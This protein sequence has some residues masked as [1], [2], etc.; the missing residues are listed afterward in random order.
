MDQRE[1]SLQERVRQQIMELIHRMDFEYSTRLLSENQLAAKFQVSRSTI[2]AVLMELETEGK[3]IRRHGSGTYVNPPALDVETTIYPR[4]NMYDLIRKN[5][6]EP[7]LK[8]LSVRDGPAGE[9]AQKLNLFPFDWITEI[10]SIYQADGHPCMYCIDC[11]DAKRFTDMDWKKHED[12]P[13]S[14]YDFIRQ[15]VG[16][17]ITWD[18]INIQAAHSGQIPALQECFSV[19]KGENKPVVRLEITNFDNRN[20]PSLLGNIY[21]D[22]DLIRLNIVRDL[23]KL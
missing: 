3:I 16:V 22:T 9:R 14:I 1:Q 5:G 23:T 10:H 21:I 18:I 20:Q 6:Y 11:V 19:P 15:S 12:Y 8:I 7:S 13:G 2:R 4:V 17:D